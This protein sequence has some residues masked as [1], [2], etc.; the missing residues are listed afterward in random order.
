[1]ILPIAGAGLGMTAFTVF[2][3]GLRHGAD[4]DHLAAIDNLTRNSIGPSRRLSRFVGTLFAG[5]HSVMILAIAM[6]AGLLGSRLAAHGALLETIGTWVSIA[7]LFLIAALN[8]RQLAKNKNGSVA[9]FKSALLPRTLRVATSPFAAIPI[10]LLFGL[11]FDTSSQVATYALAFTSGGGMFIAFLIGAI[12]S[13][14]MAVTDTLDSLLVHRLYTRHPLELVRATRIWI[15]AVTMLAVV[16]GA[17]ELAQAVGWKS[18][19]PDLAVS[20]V[21]VLTLLAVFAWTCTAVGRPATERDDPL[22]EHDDLRRDSNPTRWR[23]DAAGIIRRHTMNPSKARALGGA[24]VLAALV[25]AALL[26]GAHPVRGSDHQDSPV[27]VLRPGADIT[28]VFVYQAPDNP[29]NVVLQMDVW[30]L[31][32][33]GML[34]MTALDP[35]VMYQFK[36]DNVGDGVEHMVLQLQPNSAGT[37]QAVGVFGPG[38]PNQT[39]ITS[40]FIASSGSVNF[41]DRAAAALP[42]GVK[43]FVGP[44]K[45]P[46]FFDLLTFFNIIPDRYYGCHAPFT[47]AFGVPCSGGITG[48]FN[49]FTA[50]FNSAHGTSCSLTPPSDAL[51]S[52]SFNVI[53][54]VAE[55]PKSLIMNPAHPVIGVWATTSTTTGS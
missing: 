35:G 17:Y 7:T 3:L 48:T 12:F 49:G 27:T 8:L 44:T 47:N 32:T 36:I 40:T 46:F 50:G 30:P 55:M 1:M 53:A 21:L 31:I 41:G 10:G 4:P 5:G 20:G 18:P 54:I 26:Y 15:I 38:A 39:G 22:T 6:L 43:V 37:S 28:D 9:G 25:G 29:S 45:D 42:N 16:V 33:H 23:G 11:G 13:L 19:F 2:A 24:A 14:G 34:G 52:H 51:S